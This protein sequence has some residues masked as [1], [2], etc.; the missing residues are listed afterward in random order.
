MKKTWLSLVLLTSLMGLS[1]CKQPAEDR[2]VKDIGLRTKIQDEK[3][4]LELSVMMNLKTVVL[5]S[6]QFPITFKGINYGK[7]YMAPS[8]TQGESEVAIEINLTDVVKLQ[9]SDATLPNGGK[10]PVGGIDR[11]DVIEIEIPQVHGK[12]YIALNTI[13]SGNGKVFMGG[14]ALSIPA[15]DGIGSAVGDGQLFPF[16]KIGKVAIYAGVYTSEIP[17]QTG[18]GVFTDLSSVISKD[19][20]DMIVAQDSI[21]QEDFVRAQRGRSLSR[22][23]NTFSQG[24]KMDLRY[25]RKLKMVLGKAEKLSRPVMVKY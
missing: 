10:L 6:V 24:E 14:F 15:A 9:A 7:L 4:W 13:A 3:A 8:L 12:A 17:N 2:F 16:F 1:A 21:S 23:E 19:L 20:A 5:S 11:A 22:K 18:I 25:A